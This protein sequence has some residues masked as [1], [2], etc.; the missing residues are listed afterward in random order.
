LPPKFHLCF[1]DSLLIFSCVIDEKSKER[2][3]DKAG[4]EHDAPIASRIEQR[5]FAIMLTEALD[6]LSDRLTFGG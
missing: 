6:T 4:R 1:G 5:L 3:S 2:M